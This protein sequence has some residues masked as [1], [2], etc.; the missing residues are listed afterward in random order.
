MILH[1]GLHHLHPQYVTAAEHSSNAVKQSAA[2]M[3][4][5][6]VESMKNAFQTAA[7]LLDVAFR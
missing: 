7:M 6:P 5:L 2:L 1:K 3:P 4:P